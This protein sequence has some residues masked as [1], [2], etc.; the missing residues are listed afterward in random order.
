LF[1]T[2]PDAPKAEPRRRLVNENLGLRH[3]ALQFQV[4]VIIEDHKQS[5]HEARITTRF[6]SAR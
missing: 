3:G 4:A 1:R 2:V 6:P 5:M